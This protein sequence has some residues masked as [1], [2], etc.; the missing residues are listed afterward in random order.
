MFCATPRPHTR[1]SSAAPQASRPPLCTRRFACP[2]KAPRRGGKRA[3]R[4]SSTVCS[5]CS[6]SSAA[7]SISLL[8]TRGHGSATPPGAAPRW[9]CGQK[10]WELVA[11]GV[12]RGA[13]AHQ[14]HLHVAPPARHRCSPTGVGVPGPPSR[15]TC[16]TTRRYGALP[17]RAG[18]ACRARL[19]ALPF[20]A[21]ARDRRTT[22]PPRRPKSKGA[23]AKESS[24]G[25]AIP[26]RAVAIQVLLYGLTRRWPRA[27]PETQL[28][29]APLPSSVGAVLKTALVAWR[30]DCTC[31]C[32]CACACKVGCPGRPS[33][34]GRRRRSRELVPAAARVV[35]EMLMVPDCA[36]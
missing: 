1:F 6:R 18:F 8:R 9:S 7:A 30:Y 10:K 20:E 5:S 15:A 4:T 27:A 35:S 29:F 22:L 19:G 3:L 26:W 28:G 12:R 23:R 34:P 21:F 11:A 13:A 17:S 32:S 25:K 31:S 14:P 2:Q 24:R 36:Y 33:R 16:P